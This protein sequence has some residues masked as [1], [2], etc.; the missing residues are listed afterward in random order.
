MAY[1]ELPHFIP[2]L[3]Q[4]AAPIHPSSV[5]TAGFLVQTPLRNRRIKQQAT[6]EHFRGVF[7]RKQ[8][9]KS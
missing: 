6:L 3:A 1:I 8:F 5:Y 2:A 7:S 4:I 9:S